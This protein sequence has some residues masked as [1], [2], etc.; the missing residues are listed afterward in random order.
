M[1]HIIGRFAKSLLG[2]ITNV[3]TTEPVIALT[4]DDG[5]DPEWTP[6]LLEIMQRHKASGTFFMI[7]TLAAQNPNIV[8]RVASGGHAIGNHTWDHPSFPLVSSRERFN[9]LKRCSRVLGASV[10]RMFRPPY[11]AQNVRSRLD[12]AIAGFDVVTWNIAPT[13]WQ[14]HD[15]ETIAAGLARDACPGSIIVLH[16]RLSDALKPE[17]FNRQP[18]LDAVELL[19]KQM[20]SRFRFVTV[21]QLLQCGPARRVFWSQLPD[22][23]FLDQLKNKDGVV[24]SY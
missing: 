22:R 8:A 7:G 20:S 11:G 1:R 4:F 21:P 6:R 19:L 16:D 23:A 17:Y 3:Y 10:G 9:Q 18:T 13:D 2:T 24:R 12:L 15:A 14:D 5:P